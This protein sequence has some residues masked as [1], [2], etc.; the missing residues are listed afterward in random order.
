MPTPTLALLA[1]L[2]QTPSP[3]ALVPADATVL[4]RF[5]SLQRLADLAAAFGELSP[6]ATP[7]AGEFLPLLQYPGAAAAVD[8][9][10]PVF[11]SVSFSPEL[12]APSLAWIVPL[13]PGAEAGIDNTEGVLS[14]HQEGNYLAVHA[15]PGVERPGAPSALVAALEPGIVSVHVDLARLVELFRPLIDMGLRQGEMELASMESGEDVPFDPEEMFEWFFDKAH[16]TVD[17]AEALDLAL[18]RK[19]S[20]LELRGRYRVKAG[21]AQVFGPVST[22]PL[23]SLAGHLDPT[24]PLQLVASGTWNDFMRPMADLVDVAL[25]AYPEPLATDLGHVLELQRALSDVLLPG[26]AVSGDFTEEGIHVVYVLRAKDSARVM[27]GIQDMV[28]ALDGG[29]GMI[30]VGPAEPL[31]VGGFEGRVLPVDMRIGAVQ[32][33]AASSVGASEPEAEE[34]ARMEEALHTIYGRHLRLALASRGEYVV[35]VLA[36]NDALLRDDLA[37]LAKPALPAAKMLD[38]AEQVPAGSLGV[39]YHLDFGRMMS[40]MMSAMSGLLDQPVPLLFD[41][42]FSLDT[43]GGALDREYVGGVRLD[44]AELIAFGQKMASLEPES[45]AE[46]WLELEDEQV[47]EESEADHVHEDGK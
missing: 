45:E 19:G 10:Q 1:V 12:P 13:L 5:E 2:A 47:P 20:L 25:E 44:I 43:W 38:L 39:A 23:A 29:D 17:S 42:E 34:L 14:L 22:V 31:S 41:Q 11:I 26:I 37:R 16:E 46:E 15:R 8:P 24:H 6:D 33:L 32:A 27:A 35:M 21:S 18:G 40:R 3:A 28:L 36:N 7:A 30:A 4:V 9:A